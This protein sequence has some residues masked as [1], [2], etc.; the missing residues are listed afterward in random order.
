[1]S[2]VSN[3]RLKGFVVSVI[4]VLLLASS[5]SQLHIVPVAV[6]ADI[7]YINI[8]AMDDTRVPSDEPDT[9]FGT[10]TALDIGRWNNYVETWLRFNLSDTPSNLKLK[11]A[12]L[13]LYCQSAP[14]DPANVHVQI[15]STEIDWNGDSSGIG[16]ETTLVWNNRPS[17]LT[18]YS[19]CGFL[20]DEYSE[21]TGYRPIPINASDVEYWSKTDNQIF[22]FALRTPTQLDE[23]AYIS[24]FS[25][26]YGNNYGPVLELVFAS[27]GTEAN[28]QVAVLVD[29][30]DETYFEYYTKGV[31]KWL[32]WWKMDYK[33]IDVSTT[34]ITQSLLSNYRL[35]LIPQFN[36]TKKGH[37]SLSE[38]QAINE[39]AY[40][41]GVGLVQ[42]DATLEQYTNVWSEYNNLFDIT[43]EGWVSTSDKLGLN[44]VDNSHFVTSIYRSGSK[45]DAL[46]SDDESDLVFEAVTAGS[47]AQTL[48][49][50][51][52]NS[53]NYPAIIVKSH[54]SGRTVLATF[55]TGREYLGIYGAYDGFGERPYKTTSGMNGLLWRSIVW[56]AKKP[57]AF[58]GMPPFL[59]FRVDDVGL[60]QN[61]NTYIKK[62]VQYGFFANL[63][64]FQDEVRISSYL[65]NLIEYYRD[66]SVHVA[67][68]AWTAD[69]CIFYNYAAETEYDEYTLATYFAQLDTDYSNWDITASAI[70][71]PHFGRMGEN[72]LPFMKERE[73]IFGSMPYHIPWT[74]GDMTDWLWRSNPQRSTVVDY[75]DENDTI[76]DVYV[77]MPVGDPSQATQDCLLN[78]ATYGEDDNLTKA[79]EQMLSALEHGL[80]DLFWGEAFTHEDYASYLD[81]SQWDTVLTWVTG[82]VSSQYPFTM[83]ASREYI[84]RYVYN[85]QKLSTSYYDYS[86]DILTLNFSG[87]TDLPM[88]FYL[89]TDQKISSY[90]GILDYFRPYG[91]DGYVVWIPAYSG[92]H[93]VTITLGDSETNLPRIH[94]TMAN[95]TSTSSSA[96]QLTILAQQIWKHTDPKY[97]FEINCTTL[98]RPSIVTVGGTPVNYDYNAETKISSFNVTFSSLQEIQVSWNAPERTLHL[99]SVENTGATANLGTITF[100]GTPH[101]LPYNLA[102]LPNT[103]FAEYSP[104]SSYYVFDHWGTTG[105]VTVSD[106]NV[107]PTTV[108]FT[109]DGTL[110]AVYR[111]ASP[112]AYIYIDHT[113]IGDLVATIGVGDPS[114]PSWSKIIWNRQGGS[115]DDIELTI[116]LSDAINWLPPNTTNVWYLKVYDAAGGDQG[117]IVMFTITYGGTTY[118][119]E[120]TPVPVN[121]FQ[122]SYAYIPPPPP[123]LGTAHIYVQHTYVGDLVVTIGVGPPSS[124]Y[125]SQVIWNRQGEGQDNLD[126][127]VDLTEVAAYLPPSETYAWY[128]QVYDAAGGDEGQIVT[129][130]ITHETQT[131]SS[132]DVPVPIYDL[133]TSY[134]YIPN[135]P[136]PPPPPEGT[137]HVYI[138]H[139]YRGDLIV[140]IGVGDPASPFWSTRIWNGQG[141]S[142]NDLDLTVDLTEAVVYLPPSETYSWYLKVYD[143]AG[144]DQGQI[145][146]FTVTYG[147]T[148]YSSPDVPVPIY[149]LQTC[150]AYI[151]EEPPPPPPPDDTAHIYIQHT[152]VGDL[153]VTIGVG[154]P[155]S[156]YWSQMIWNRQGEGQD[157]LDLTVDISDQ[158]QYLPPSGTYTWYVKVYDAANED[159]GQIV[160]FTITHEGQTYTSSDPPVPI[161]DQKTSYAYIRGDG[162]SPSYSNVSTSTTVAG[163]V[164]QFS[165]KWT[166][167]SGLSGY[168]FGC[169]NTGTWIN[170]TWTSLS[171]TEAWANVTKTLDSTVG[172]TIQYRWWC[173]NTDDSWTF[174]PLYSL[175]TTEGGILGQLDIYDTQ[176]LLHFPCQRKVFYAQN[177]HWVFYGN[178]STGNIEYRTSTDGLIFTPVTTVRA[179]E[180][181][182]ATWNNATHIVIVTDDADGS[183]KFRMGLLNSDGTITWLDEWQTPLSQTNIDMTRP[184]VI[185]DQFGCPWIIVNRVHTLDNSRDVYV[186]R[187]QWTNGTWRDASG[188]PIVISD[189][190]DYHA[191]RGQLHELRDEGMYALWYVYDI[192]LRG[193]LYNYT[194]S[195]WETEEVS[196]DIAP[197]RLV[198]V[199]DSNNVI[200]MILAPHGNDETTNIYYMNRTSSGFGTPMLIGVADTSPPYREISINVDGTDLYLF[201]KETSTT[202]MSMNFTDGQWHDPFL[203]KTTGPSD[204]YCGIQTSYR[205]ENN[206]ICVAWVEQTGELFIYT[207][208]YDYIEV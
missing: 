145:I 183:V 165:C 168:I 191:Y 169:N 7:D 30:T 35:I 62:L 14:G 24:A 92:N 53:E 28:S 96:S 89:F 85:R 54:G 94:Y 60:V 194:S 117:Q 36:L 174:T 19:S 16:D 126:L 83:T 143:A 184:N 43:I 190:I 73:W 175:T 29:P 22:S 116:N 15:Y 197:K 5:F 78:A 101:M 115:A 107:N 67:P 95:I 51:L 193:R 173:N 131:Y 61:D 69:H 111:T 91:E 162:T 128:L 21:D 147:G 202:I 195:T 105:G 155:S 196:S 93:Q 181:T 201:W 34:E 49:T 182:F 31:E 136:P 100:N 150:Y 90:S 207:L 64:V 141:G 38:L 178:D 17:Y 129:F 65:N 44:V 20:G 86:G 11:A 206:M 37:L 121:D 66:G 113:W 164:C 166:D 39:T 205:V 114:V 153:V 130:T 18:N 3:R 88:A 167:D 102:L 161:I 148:T 176:L 72:V 104:P 188:F 57:F 82:N 58:M 171:G 70:T 118:S 186:T 156:P 185:V 158:L 109:E 77:A 1:M 154:P 59:T 160:T 159:Q 2:H 76:F 204:L 79:T 151:P 48:V 139:T 41:D 6:K 50:M 180:D 110:A 177:R 140:Y 203:W 40:E 120:D 47:S 106:P 13:K 208:K 125:W 112:T 71:V 99:E 46:Y 103:Y 56:A 33:E 8:Y 179:T 97:L 146:T 200:H 199:V 4:L 163:A 23:N 189:S 98:G 135:A 142:A 170:E 27:E 32:E 123:P 108:I 45:M 119:S 63:Y 80:A 157:N 124:P 187:S 68:H 198:A 138:E 10:D 149:D 74:E 84:A 75:A 42:L 9:N 25:K 133:Q 26:E 127:T 137:A 132:P 52:Y 192:D 87:T 152:Y 134:A 55:S 172:D 122:T 12:T 144:G 81:S